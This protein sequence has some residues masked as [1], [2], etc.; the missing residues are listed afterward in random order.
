MPKADKLLV[1]KIQIGNEV[2]TIVSGIAKSYTPEQIIGK[3]VVVVAN[4]TPVKLRGVLSEGMILCADDG[5]GG[6]A[7][8]SP[9]SVV[10]SGS[11]VR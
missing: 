9:E 4:L 7:L 5:K 6:L 2:R 3:E 1:N 10:L 11:E 8:V